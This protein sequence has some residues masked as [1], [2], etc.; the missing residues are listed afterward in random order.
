[1]QALH[2]EQYAHLQALARAWTRSHL[3]A[4]KREP[5]FN[6]HL[7]ADALCFQ[8]QGSGLLGALVT[9][10]SL[11]L[12]WLPEGPPEAVPAQDEPLDLT[13][14]AGRFRLT[15]EVLSDD[16]CFWRLE[17]LDDLTDVTSRQ[18][19]SRLAQR[20]MERLMTPPSPAT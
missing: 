20:L 7:C 3:R 19:A 1:M 5:R 9:P 11:S 12:A 6:P 14:P 4:A 8:P 15:P 13:L 17:L 16:L 18:E 2:P 10:V